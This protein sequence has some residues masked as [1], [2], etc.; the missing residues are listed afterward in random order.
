MEISP[1]SEPSQVCGFSADSGICMSMSDIGWWPTCFLDPP[2]P[3]CTEAALGP[4]SQFSLCSGGDMVPG[5]KSW[6]QGRQKPSHPHHRPSFRA[7]WR[8][9]LCGGWGFPPWVP[10]TWNAKGLNLINFSGPGLFHLSPHPASWGGGTKVLPSQTEARDLSG[11]VG[12]Y[13]RASGIL[14]KLWLASGLDPGQIRAE[15]DLYPALK[16]L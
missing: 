5:V 15:W 14:I 3:S 16:S 11:S 8:S 4:A 2:A 10:V 6:Q 7:P 1:P 9:L 12:K 13:N